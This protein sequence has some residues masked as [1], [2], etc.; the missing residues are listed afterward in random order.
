MNKQLE[1]VTAEYN[2]DISK[3]HHAHG[4]GNGGGGMSITSGELNANLKPR[5]AD[6]R[7]YPENRKYNKKNTKKHQHAREKP[8]KDKNNYR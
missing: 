7:S 4:G 5:N 1:L 2:V 6:G 3:E 8:S